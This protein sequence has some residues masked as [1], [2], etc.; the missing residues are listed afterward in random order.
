M[1]AV[2][3]GRQKEYEKINKNQKYE[4]LKTYHQASLNMKRKDVSSVRIGSVFASSCEL[5]A[6]KGFLAD[7]WNG[8][9]NRKWLRAREQCLA[10]VNM[11]E[12][13]ESRKKLGRAWTEKK[14]K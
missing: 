12:M 3:L 11:G 7:G 1:L 2:I 13:N 5:S 4:R 8:A 10:N 14:T 6:S 9:Q